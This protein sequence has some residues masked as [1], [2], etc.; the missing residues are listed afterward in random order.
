MH[1]LEKGET[2]PPPEETQRG[3]A[4]QRGGGGGHLPRESKPLLQRAHMHNAKRHGALVDPKVHA[5]LAAP[6]ASTR[7]AALESL[8]ELEPEELVQHGAAIAARFE[9]RQKDVRCAALHALSRMPPTALFDY[10]PA[11]LERLQDN[12]H[13]V[14]EAAQDL[15]ELLDSASGLPPS[16]ALQMRRLEDSDASVRSVAVQALAGEAATLERLM[17]VLVQNLRRP[18]WHVRIGA[19]EALAALPAAALASCMREVA[20]CVRDAHASVRHKALHVLELLAPADLAEVAPQAA[21]LIDEADP[22]IVEAAISL[23]T[24]L[25]PLALAAYAEQIGC[26]KFD[27]HADVRAAAQRAMAKLRD[28]ESTAAR[29]PDRAVEAEREGVGLR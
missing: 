13:G 24:R 4:G 26:C 25:E 23:L 14:R 18:R 28:A 5:Q 3:A 6:R 19:L 27:E 21:P 15:L 20:A 17:P 10:A 9:D 7:Q 16:A 22:F 11:I 8:A 29:E 2:L 12:N 1:A